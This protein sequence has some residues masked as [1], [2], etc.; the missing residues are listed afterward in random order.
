MVEAMFEQSPSYFKQF[1]KQCKFLVTNEQINFSSV[2][3]FAVCS[4]FGSKFCQLTTTTSTDHFHV[5]ID[6]SEAATIYDDIFERNKAFPVS[7]RY[8]DLNQS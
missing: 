5:L 1:Q 4:N 3:T 7:C 2:K 6:A 8:V